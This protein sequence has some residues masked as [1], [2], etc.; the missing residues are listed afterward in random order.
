VAVATGWG[1]PETT[2]TEPP[3]GCAVG[4]LRTCSPQPSPS[5]ATTTW[6]MLRKTPA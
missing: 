4:C 5:P 2:D 3:T 6:R 1:G